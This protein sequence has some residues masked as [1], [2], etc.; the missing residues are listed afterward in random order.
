MRHSRSAELIESDPEIDK[1]FNRLLKKRLDREKAMAKQNER[2]ALRDY[3]V[4]S[5]TR[6]NSCIITPTIQ[7]NNFKL[8][9]ELIQTVQHT[10]QFGRFPHDD[11][12]EYNSSFLE[13]CDIERINSVSLEVIKLKLFSFSL[14]DKAKTWFNSLPKNTIAIWDEMAS[15]FLTKYFPPSKA[16]KLR[17]DLITFTHLESESIYEA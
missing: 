15:R 9:P 2:Q 3:A 10:C 13:I 8:N 4:P 12:N 5:L 17:G 1:T 7:A 14:K 16:A 6:A 11:P